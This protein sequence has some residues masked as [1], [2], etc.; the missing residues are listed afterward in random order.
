MSPRALKIALA[1]SVA[2]NLFAVAG[3]VTAWIA[4]DRAV[5]QAEAQGRPGREDRLGTLLQPLPQE[6]R[7]RIRADLRASALT[8]RPDFDAA[9]A[10][11]RQA[12]ERAS[13]EPFNPAEVQAL[14]EP[15]RLAE[16]RGRARLER[17]AVTLMAG[18]PAAERRALA[19]ILARRSDARTPE[20]PPPAP[21]RP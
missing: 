10:A 4:Q 12:I 3:G 21:P 17:N 14:M 8:A 9:R 11:R 18:L 20:T 1:L 15:A 7:E 6:T 13:A 19:P 16:M 2:V 5:K